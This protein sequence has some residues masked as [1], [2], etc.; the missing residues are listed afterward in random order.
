[1]ETSEQITPETFPEKR[2]P[3]RAAKHIVTEETIRQLTAQGL[4]TNKIAEILGMAPDNV[5]RHKTRMRERGEDLPALV[6]AVRNE[7]LGLVVDKFLDAG[8]KKSLKIRASDVLGAAKLYADRSHPVRRGE[9]PD[10]P[11]SFT[12]VNFNVTVNQGAN[13]QSKEIDVTE[14][15]VTSDDEVGKSEVLESK[16]EMIELDLT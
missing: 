1:M 10:G 7:K 3:R 16:G 6:S 4:G 8:A 12:Q 2:K 9:D 14:R 11:V 5:S 15:L 13:P